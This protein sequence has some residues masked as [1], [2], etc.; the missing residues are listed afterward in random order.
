[1]VTDGGA[2]AMIQPKESKIFEGAGRS[3]RLP[4]EILAAEFI[5]RG[6]KIRLLR[7]WETDLRLLMV[8]SEEN[9]SGDGQGWVAE[10]L[11]QVHAALDELGV[12]Q[13]ETAG[14]PNKAGAS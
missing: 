10:R 1:M 13:S 6:E 12:E 5:D 9:M 11:Q 7:Q 4:S 14:V 2:I 3:F 8:A